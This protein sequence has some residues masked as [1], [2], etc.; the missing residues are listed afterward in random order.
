MPRA[1]GDARPSLIASDPN[2]TGGAV[3]TY[4]G[5]PLY[6]YAEDSQPHIATGQAIDVDGGF[7]Y[8]IRPDGTPLVP[9]GNPPTN[10]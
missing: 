2:P 1:A 4:G 5:W 7:W 9:P 6:T 8:L 3:A 10:S